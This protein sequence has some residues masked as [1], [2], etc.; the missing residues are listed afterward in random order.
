M[1]QRIRTHFI[2]RRSEHSVSH[3]YNQVEN[4]SQTEH[5]DGKIWV[6][7]GGEEGQYQNG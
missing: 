3:K 6:K 7:M 1:E 5:N 4:C 2:W